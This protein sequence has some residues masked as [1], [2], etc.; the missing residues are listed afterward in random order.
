MLCYLSV[1]EDNVN[2]VMKG[3]ASFFRGRPKSSTP[4]LLTFLSLL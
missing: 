4:H 2:M 1:K 3:R